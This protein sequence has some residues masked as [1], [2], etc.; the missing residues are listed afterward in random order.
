VPDPVLDLHG[1][2]VAEAIRRTSVFLVTEQQRGTSVVRIITGHGSGAI[3]QA[4]R[5]MLQTHPAVLRSSPAL[6]SDAVTLV[7]LKPPPSRRSGR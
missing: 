3:K 6:E 2:R 4:I 7:V 1:F 5:S